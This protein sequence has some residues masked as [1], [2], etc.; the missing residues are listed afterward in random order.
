MTADP[1]QPPPVA[2]PRRLSRLAL[3]VI[4]G[5][6]TLGFLFV[7]GFVGI[8]I[9]GHK[10][11]ERDIRYEVTGSA[12]K[13]TVVYRADVDEHADTRDETVRGAVLPWSTEYHTNWMVASA[14][15]QVLRDDSDP[16][17]IGCTISVDG[18]VVARETSGEKD[19]T[20][21]CLEPGR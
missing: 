18:Q 8:A 10:K 14:R 11:S 3:T 7:A 6:G 21:V 19:L 5:V 2:S 1:P 15:L 20:I 12:T 4:I 17:T 9:W 16:G 13:V